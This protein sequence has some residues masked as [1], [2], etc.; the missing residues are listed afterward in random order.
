[1]LLWTST[2]SLITFLLVLLPASS[3]AVV[4]PLLMRFP[5]PNKPTTSSD[6]VSFAAQSGNQTS[7]SAHPDVFIWLDFYDAP[8]CP[9]DH[10]VGSFQVAENDLAPSYGT[11]LLPFL[12]QTRSMSVRKIPPGVSVIL[13]DARTS[14]PHRVSVLAQESVG[15]TEGGEAASSGS[16]SSSPP[17]VC[18]KDFGENGRYGERGE[19]QVQ[20]EDLASPYQTGSD[21]NGRKD[22]FT[23]L[24]F[25]ILPFVVL[26]SL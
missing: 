10:L 26:P 3:L 20:L 12:L 13:S 14:P 6:Q 4:P 15:E 25:S 1:M 7:S 2:F 22:G 23:E 8:G 18:I 21:G 9:A 5:D 19:V 17:A 24:S 11:Q 16:S